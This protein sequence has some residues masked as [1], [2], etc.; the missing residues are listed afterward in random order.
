MDNAMKTSNLTNSKYYMHHDPATLI[1][2]T[3]NLC[4]LQ[5]KMCHQNSSDFVVGD[6]PHIPLEMIRD[7]ASIANQ[8]KSIYLLGAGEPLM[9]PDIYEI[10]KI[11]KKA[12]QMLRLVQPLMEFY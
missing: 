5:C 7:I 3:T 11:F 6:K 1:V 2:D 4:N 10:I 8:A 12:V 9:H